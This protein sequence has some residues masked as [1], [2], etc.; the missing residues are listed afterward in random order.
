MRAECICHRI[1][2]LAVPFIW[3]QACPGLYLDT[4]RVEWG[5]GARKPQA[6]PPER[7]KR[8]HRLCVGRYVHGCH[9]K[10]SPHES[11]PPSQW[12]WLH[13]PVCGDKACQQMSGRFPEL[14]T[15][16]RTGV[17]RGN[18]YS[19]KCSGK[20][21]KLLSTKPSLSV[22]KI[23]QHWYIELFLII[24]LLNFYWGDIMDWDGQ[25]RGKQRE[26]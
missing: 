12:R 13:S 19:L 21:T 17:Q 10:S 8:L 9:A 24:S 18:P 20:H 7:P 2:S 25:E 5:L 6:R 22:A 15:E 4:G 23:E 16:V 11:L 3:V 26:I 1:P 14:L